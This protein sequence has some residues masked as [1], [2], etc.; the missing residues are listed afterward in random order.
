MD[1]NGDECDRGKKENICRER[2]HNRKIRGT[3][4][5]K[6]SRFYRSQDFI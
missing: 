5:I 3:T 1:G 6:A 2:K 4:I